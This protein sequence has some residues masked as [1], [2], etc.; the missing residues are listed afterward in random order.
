M[1]M[2]YGLS[3]MALRKDV[4]AA[5]YEEAAIADPEILA[6]IPR[7]TIEE[8]GELESRGAAFRHAARLRITTIDGRTF[9]REVL[10]RRGSPENPVRRSD[11]ERKFNAN[12]DRLLAPA[13]RDRLIAL[14]ASLEML[15]NVAAI[16]EI[17]SAP[18]ATRPDGATRST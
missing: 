1:N 16:N 3:V 11:I 13:T 15:P 2:Y 12:V 17:V 18:L 5:D 6:F 4:S 10:H 14:C 8:D 9:T 7:I